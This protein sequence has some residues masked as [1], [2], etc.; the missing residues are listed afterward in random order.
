MELK[1]AK[2]D[3]GFFYKKLLIE[4]NGIEIRAVKPLPSVGGYF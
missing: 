1:S 3:R 4:P 2:I